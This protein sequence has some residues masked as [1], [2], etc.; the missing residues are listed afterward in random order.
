MRSPYRSGRRCW[1][2][3]LF[4]RALRICF[5]L[6]VAVIYDSVL[7]GQRA[8]I[9]RKSFRPHGDTPGNGSI[10]RCDR[11]AFSCE[12]VNRFQ[13]L[14]AKPCNRRRVGSRRVIGIPWGQRRQLA[15]YRLHP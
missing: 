8:A 12:S 5:R 2:L 11:D 7:S 1:K 9:C 6:I 10:A 14:P 13:S 3:R 15:S 4:A